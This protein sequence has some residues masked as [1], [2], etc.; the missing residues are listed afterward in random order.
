ML[1]ESG[2]KKIRDLCRKKYEVK[3]NSPAFEKLDKSPKINEIL[4]KVAWS[5]ALS[6]ADTPQLMISINADSW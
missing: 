6:K 1:R 5:Y 4:K 3:Q 2:R